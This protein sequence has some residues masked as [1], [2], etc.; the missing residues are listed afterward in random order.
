M[1]R[2][3]V[4][5]AALAVTLTSV[6]LLLEFESSNKRSVGTANAANGLSSGGTVKALAAAAPPNAGC[7]KEL[8]STTDIDSSASGL[9]ADV[10]DRVKG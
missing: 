1:L 2:A 4:A 8:L 9:V 7:S 3:L 10:L 6:G 5:M